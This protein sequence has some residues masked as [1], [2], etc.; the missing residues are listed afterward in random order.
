MCP[1][2]QRVKAYTSSHKVRGNS[3]SVGED[4]DPYHG[5]CGFKR[6]CRRLH[7]LLL[8]RGCACARV[9]VRLQQVGGRRTA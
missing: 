5:E 4:L 7:V 3:M 6:G 2:L 8:N 1:P 9:R